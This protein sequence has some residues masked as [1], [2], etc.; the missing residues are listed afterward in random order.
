MSPAIIRRMNASS[1]HTFAPEI[2]VRILDERLHAWGLPR[3]QTDLA[4]GIDLIASLD[5]PL[6]IEPQ[7]AAQP[8]FM[9][10]G[11]F[12]P[13]VPVA[14]GEAG[15]QALRSFGFDPQWQRYPMQHQ[16]CAEEIRDLGD[17]L[18]VRFAAGAD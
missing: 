7:A 16:V 8:L 10:H 5:A 14:A 3:Y 15:M 6:R 18:A 4:A 11:S 9:A 13:V 12:D 1:A 2:E 17:W